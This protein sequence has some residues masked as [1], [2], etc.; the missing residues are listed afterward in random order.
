MEIL[1]DLGDIDITLEELLSKR[2]I[3]ECMRRTRREFYDWAKLNGNLVGLCRGDYD[4]FCD[5]KFLFDQEDNVCLAQIE[6]LLDRI[7]NEDDDEG[8]ILENLRDRLE[9]LERKESA[10]M[11]GSAFDHG[12]DMGGI[13]DL[14]MLY[15]HDAISE[16]ERLVLSAV[17]NGLAIIFIIAIIAIGRICWIFYFSNDAIQRSMENEKAM[18]NLGDHDKKKYGKLSSSDESDDDG[19]DEEEF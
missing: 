5:K 1:E 13:E 16:T 6:K 4:I 2:G 10:K 17:L 7:E 12:S 8:T 18:I 3:N 11:T 19:L 15:G 9:N 14:H